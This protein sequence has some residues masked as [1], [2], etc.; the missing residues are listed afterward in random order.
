MA[1]FLVTYQI[2]SRITQIVRKASR[3]IGI[4]S[5][6]LK[7]SDEIKGRLEDASREGKEIFIIYGKDELSSDVEDFLSGI[8]NL[9]LFYH[10][11]LH[12]KC[13]FNEH[14]V[15]IT[16][17]NLYEY[18]ER[19]N[20]EMG[21]AAKS[22][23]AIYIDALREVESILNQAEKQKTSESE[24]NGYLDRIFGS[25]RQNGNNSSSSRSSKK[26]MAK[27]K[28]P[29]EGHCIR[30]SE[31]IDHDPSRP[32]CRDCFKIWVRY[33]D[34]DYEEDYCHTCGKENQTS[35][36]RPQCKPC[37]RRTVH[38]ARSNS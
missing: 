3:R 12:A 11:D 6:Y 25:S 13:Y 20:R 35:M 9:S 29:E 27:K 21:I 34:E 37:W 10:E 28:S 24:P 16:S 17:M 14:E 33:E 2:S 30:C 19:N 22:D 18:S 15:V 1:E 32:Y 31:P 26:K 38:Y 4:V 5:P 8:N 36:N 7:F 23:D